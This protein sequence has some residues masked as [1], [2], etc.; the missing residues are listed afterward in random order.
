MTLTG[1]PPGTV[2]EITGITQSNPG[3]VT[4]LSVTKANSFPIAVGQTVTISKVVGMTQI[5]DLRFIVGGFDPDA[6]TFNL[7]DLY[8]RPFSTIQ[9][10]PYIS[11]GELNIISYSATATQPPGLMYNNQ[12]S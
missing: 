7:I 10:S 5:N 8:Y 12:A 6:K 2:Y 9:F 4:L 1:F 3:V 11:G